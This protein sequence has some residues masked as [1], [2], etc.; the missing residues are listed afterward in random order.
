MCPGAVSP[1][2][3]EYKAAREVWLLAMETQRSE[4]FW[5]LHNLLNEC[6]APLLFMPP[7]D[8]RRPVSPASRFPCREQTRVRQPSSTIASPMRRVQAAGGLKLG[9]LLDVS[10]LYIRGKLC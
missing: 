7:R 9:S 2:P 8:P 6:A 5:S 3:L 4:T 10:Y 1:G